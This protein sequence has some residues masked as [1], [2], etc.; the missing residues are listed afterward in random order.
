M[1]PTGDT[2]VKTYT[3]APQSRFNIW[4]DLEDAALANTAVSTILESTNGVPV[5]AERSMWWPANSPAG[6]HEAHNSAGA[7]DTGTQLASPEENWV[8]TTR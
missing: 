1:L 2:L 5:I 8:A 6:W 4:V 7:T 3:V